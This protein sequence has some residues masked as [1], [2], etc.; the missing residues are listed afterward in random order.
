MVDKTIGTIAFLDFRAAIRALHLD[1]LKPMQRLQLAS[2]L[3][4]AF[5]LLDPKKTRS[6][7]HADLELYLRQLTI[8]IQSHVSPVDSVAMGSDLDVALPGVLP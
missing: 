7:M 3:D 1:E 8:R 6:V 4:K 5:N 2:L